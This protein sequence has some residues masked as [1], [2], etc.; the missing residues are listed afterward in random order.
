MAK[1]LLV[2]V[3]VAC[4][5]A[6]GEIGNTFMQLGGT[7][8]EKVEEFNAPNT[9]CFELYEHP[10]FRGAK[11]TLCGRRGQCI[12]V[13]NHEYVS[14]IRFLSGG[15]FF[16]VQRLRV[17]KLNNCERYLDADGYD[18]YNTAMLVWND[19]YHRCDGYDLTKYPCESSF[20]D[21]INSISF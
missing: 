13:P 19:G 11:R 12:D 9:A 4:C 3:L 17:Y 21:N 16:T 7:I 15:R 2:L 6:A 18:A 14:S 20:N 5:A 1:C 8:Y 10:G